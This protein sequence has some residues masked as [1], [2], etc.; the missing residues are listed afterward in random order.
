MEAVNL[1]YDH[2]RREKAESQ[3]RL[4]TPK[5]ER[6]SDGFAKRSADKSTRQMMSS[7]DAHSRKS[8]SKAARP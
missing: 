4:F 2:Q 3:K 6:Q 8:S 5:R 7:T 1:L